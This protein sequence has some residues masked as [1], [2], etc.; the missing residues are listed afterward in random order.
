MQKCIS[1]N[2]WGLIFE[3]CKSA[4]TVKFNFFENFWLYGIWGN[5]GC[6]STHWHYRENTNHLMQDN[7]P[8]HVF[9]L[10]QK[11]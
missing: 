4:K 9:K 2:I 10:G 11:F 3:V 1:F 7:D 8:K 5:H 6:S